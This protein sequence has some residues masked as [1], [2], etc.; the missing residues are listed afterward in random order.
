M[1]EAF[2]PIQLRTADLEFISSRRLSPHEVA[3]LIRLEP[4]QV[5]HIVRREFRIDEIQ[6]HFLAAL[7]WRHPVLFP[8]DV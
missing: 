1:A 8:E 2:S 6:S 7:A 5:H 4:S 3:R